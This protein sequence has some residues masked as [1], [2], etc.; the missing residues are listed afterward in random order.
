MIFINSSSFKHTAV[1]VLTCSFNPRRHYLQRV[2][3]SLSAQSIGADN[4]EYIFVD[5]S[6]TQFPEID[7]SSLPNQKRIQEAK[8]GKINALLTGLHECAGKLI[9]IVDDDNVLASNYLEEAWRVYERMPF[10]GVWGGQIFPEFEE[11]PAPELVPY[12]HLLTLHEFNKFEWT[13]RHTGRCVAGAGM[14][15]RPEVAERFQRNVQENSLIRSL[16]RTGVAIPGV[17]D[18]ETAM[19]ACDIG[20]GMGRIPELK[21]THLI[22]RRRVQKEYLLTLQENAA[23]AYQ[24]YVT[25][26][27]ELASLRYWKP[28][29]FRRWIE[30]LREYRYDQITRE[31]RRAYRRGL[32]RAERGRH[33]TRIR[34]PSR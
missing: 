9:V 30:F 18:W 10:L 19:T 34:L 6:S 5:N 13:N 28:S 12:I 8:P 21:L 14:C 20:L 3:D 25:S 16:G 7:F 24:R 23:Y 15:L 29:F 33:P 2:V 31:F 1:S 22:P 26:R 4:F 32:M 11:A 17:D 27:P